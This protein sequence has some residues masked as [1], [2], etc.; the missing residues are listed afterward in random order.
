MEKRLEV[1][2][3]CK[4]CRKSLGVYYTV[5]FHI[6]NVGMY[7]ISYTI[8]CPHCGKRTDS[9]VLINRMMYAVPDKSD[10]IYA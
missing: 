4:V 10:R 6:D 5:D 8:K 3:H 7:E 1:T 9:S 2:I